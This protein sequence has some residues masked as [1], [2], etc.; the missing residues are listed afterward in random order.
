M[1][2]KIFSLIA[3]PLAVFVT[4]ARAEWREASSDHFLIYAD[5][6]E[7]WTRKFADRLERFDAMMRLRSNLKTA[8]EQRSNRLV[9]YILDSPEAVAKIC[10]NCRNVAGF[11]SP[12]VGGSVVYTARTRGDG[13]L[14]LDAETILFHEYSHHLMLENFAVA[15]P[16]WFIEGYAE[17]NS[18][19]EV[20]RDGSMLVGAPAR[21]RA[22][23]LIL[24]DKLPITELLDRAARM[25]G[26]QI[27]VFYGRA[28]VLTHLLLTDPARA[29]QLAKY[30]K[31]FAEGKKSID[32]AT[33]AFGDLRAL[34]RDISRAIGKPFAY[35][36]FPAAAIKPVTVAMRT[37]TPGEAATMPVRLRSDRGVDRKAALAL[38][39]EAQKRAAPF[40]ADPGAQEV[41]AEAEFDAGNWAAAEAAADRA[42]AAD[43]K[44]LQALIYKGRSVMRRT[45][46]AKATD[47]A[48]WGEV[49]R[50]FIRA[51][52]VDPNAAEPLMRF[53]QIFV[54]RDQ[55]PT[56]NAAL[57]LYRAFELSP[58]AAELRVL[59]ARQLLFDDKPA[60]ARQTLLPLAYDPHG[61]PGSKLAGLIVAAID[62]G[63]P[64]RTIARLGAKAGQANDALEL[65]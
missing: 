5:A 32:A 19:F 55:K 14:S 30:L 35:K 54:A 27:G 18:T 45:V 9:V 31:A 62:A 17:Y 37:L 11:Y 48:A 64:A 15:Y 13:P 12:R 6:G 53:Y 24:G 25:T 43:P 47:D 51:N 59:A 42:L 44:R 52:K 41:L 46:E 22:Y 26:E 7:E 40:P 16:S 56:A 36:R 28:W 49:R 65:D 2:R 38:L 29:G 1:L 33:E 57:G 20:E 3:L 34:D 8:P 63:I 61:S 60:D 23:S 50:W 10:G 4:P 58:Q 39:P 21:H